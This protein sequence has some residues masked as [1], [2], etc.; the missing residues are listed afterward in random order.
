MSKAKKSN[1]EAKKPPV[2]GAGKSLSAYQSGKLSASKFE[3]TPVTKKK[4]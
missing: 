2:V 4:S 1:V 3:I